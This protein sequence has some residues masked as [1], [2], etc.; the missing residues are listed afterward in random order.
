MQPTV[1][2]GA[3]WNLHPWHHNSSNVGGVTAGQ[4]THNSSRSNPSNTPDFAESRDAVTVIYLKI[5][6]MSFKSLV[7]TFQLIHRSPTSTHNKL[8]MW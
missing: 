4:V 2:V 8:R 7:Q 5:F 1:V 6:F 3:D